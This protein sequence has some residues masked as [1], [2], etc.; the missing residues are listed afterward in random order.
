MKFKGVFSAAILAAVL[1]I[2]G[3]LLAYSGGTG[4]PNDPYQIANVADFNQLSIDPNNWNKSF[5]LTADIN[6]ASLTF[7]KAPVAPDVNTSSN[8]QGIQFTGFFD[9]NGHTISKLTIIASTKDF[10]GLFGYVD[11]GGQIRNLGVKD[12]NITGRYLVGGLVG[13]NPSGTI[14]ACYATGT[15]S[16]YFFVGRLV[17]YNDGILTSCYATGSVTGTGNYVGGLVGWNNNGTLISC[18]ATSSVSG[19][20][21]AGGLAGYNYG[22]TLTS[23]YSTGSVSGTNYAGGLVGHN[24]SGTLT[25]CYATGSVSGTNDAGGLVGWNLDGALTSCYA[26]GSV[27]GTGSGVGGL[28][29]WNDSGSL[30]SCYATG[31]VTG[32]GN[33]VGGL[34]GESGGSL[35]S[36]YSTGSVNGSQDVGG[37]VGGIYSGST[38]SGC[39]WD[40][41]TSGT[42]DGVGNVNPD[43]NGAMGKTTAEMMT[44]STFTDANGLWDFLGETTNG[45]DDY[46]RMCV[47]GVDYPRLTWGYVQ[48]GDFACPDGVGFDDL[49]RFGDDWLLTYSTTF[50]GTDANGDKVV[51]FLDFARL[52]ENWLNH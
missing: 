49:Q 19:T 48:D 46:W 45:T 36:C 25:S 35:T 3:N 27:T 34:V 42:S 10:I 50:Y 52:A 37:L 1:C 24:R 40:T 12:V 20:D 13:R 31:S 11:S 47:D 16:G 26:T 15:I 6:L 8:F 5:I 32:T 28:V 44:L 21:Y 14:T 51:N 2:S 30:I 22:G 39:F 29:G 38:I 41:Q 33:Y 4:E 17:G 7:T 9:G 23:C 43:P 18:Y